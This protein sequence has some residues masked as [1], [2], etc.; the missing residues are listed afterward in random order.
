[1]RFGELRIDGQGLF[2]LAAGPLGVA[3]AQIPFAVAQGA[4]SLAVRVPQEAGGADGADGARR[5]LFVDV[6]R[7]GQAESADLGEGPLHDVAAGI[8]DHKF[9]RPGGQ[10]VEKEFAAG[11]HQGPRGVP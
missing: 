3:V 7:K 1:V 9:M 6:E 4:Q 5:R 2:E 10:V 8:Q 11:R